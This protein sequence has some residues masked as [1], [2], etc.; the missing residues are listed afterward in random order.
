MPS[1]SSSVIGGEGGASARMRILA[2]RGL[3]SSGILPGIV[4]WALVAARIVRT[5]DRRLTVEATDLRPG[6]ARAHHRR[7]AAFRRRLPLGMLVF[8]LRDFAM[9]LPGSNTSASVI[10]GQRSCCARRW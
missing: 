9:Y 3:G 4:G 5:V 8:G 7:L 2:V 10:R 6:A 1:R